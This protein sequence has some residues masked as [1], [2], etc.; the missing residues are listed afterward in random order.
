MDELN[1]ARLQE[2][3]LLMTPEE[4][5]TRMAIQIRSIS[6]PTRMEH[7]PQWSL[8]T[9]LHRTFHSDY[10]KHHTSFPTELPP[11]ATLNKIVQTVTEEYRTIDRAE[12]PQGQRYRNYQNF[13]E[14]QAREFILGRIAGWL[15]VTNTVAQGR[16][17][18][19]NIFR[20][21]KREWTYA[22]EWHPPWCLR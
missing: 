16:Q 19:I 11:T 1:H 6:S 18:D 12:W 4:V 5:T 21:N 10:R 22:K 3:N 7:D 20:P 2:E 15:L 9:R 14:Y 8:S 13:S 17:P